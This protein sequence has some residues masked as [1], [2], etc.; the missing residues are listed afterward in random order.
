MTRTRTP[1]VRRAA[2]LAAAT[3]LALALTACGGDDSDGEARDD[4]PA[5]STSSADAGLPD[6]AP[7]IETDGDDVTGLDFTDTP[8]PSDQLEVAVV[9]EG[10]G[11]EV[12]AGDSI[13]VHYYGSLYDSDE[14]FDESYSGGQP[15]TFGIGVGQVIPGWDQG[16]PGV[17]VGSRIIMSIPADLAYGEQGSPPVI[18]ANA[19][20]YFVVD[21]IS[22][23]DGT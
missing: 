6:W 19:P 5:T 15:A 2:A 4:N 21:I 23:D 12:K 7:A 1:L 13:T 10:D 17:K 3:A 18:P 11:A 9:K 16:I 14:P 20:L 8:E 22:V